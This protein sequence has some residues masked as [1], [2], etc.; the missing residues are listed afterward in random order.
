MAQCLAAITTT[1]EMTTK[2]DQ[3]E[4][5]LKG[6]VSSFP[7]QQPWWNY[8]YIHIIRDFAL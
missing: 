1:G 5:W 4:K 3:L 6:V 8:K 7:H 2:D